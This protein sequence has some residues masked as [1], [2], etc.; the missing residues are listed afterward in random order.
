MDS[1]L[2]KAPGTYF[3]HTSVTVCL[4]GNR[5]IES[6]K[7]KSNT[8]KRTYLSASCKPLLT[9]WTSTDTS[10]VNWDRGDARSTRLYWLLAP[11]V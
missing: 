3:A 6:S 8:A 5:T 9:Q 1:T 10:A 4:L 2:F 11:R 7:I